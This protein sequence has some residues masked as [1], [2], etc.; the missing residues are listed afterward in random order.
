VILV[1]I[2]RPCIRRTEV[3]SNNARSRNADVIVAVR[4]VRGRPT[5]TS[6][7]ERSKNGTD[8]QAP[9]LL[10]I[11]DALEKEPAAW[12]RAERKRTWNGYPVSC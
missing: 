7:F 2:C 11:Y 5:R 9:K 1:D 12:I 6:G 8:D 3:V 10:M 4:R